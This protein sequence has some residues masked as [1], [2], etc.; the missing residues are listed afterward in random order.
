MKSLKNR[1]GTSNKRR[2]RQQGW[3]VLLY[4][5]QPPPSPC[6][7]RDLLEEEEESLLRQT[8]GHNCPCLDSPKRGGG[9][10]HLS[11][12]TG[13]KK[14]KLGRRLSSSSTTSGSGEEKGLCL[15][16]TVMVGNAVRSTRWE[17]S[18][19]RRRMDRDDA[20]W[21]TTE[22]SRATQALSSLRLVPMALLPCNSWKSLAFA[23][24][25]LNPSGLFYLNIS[26]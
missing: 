22:G 16:S 2:W 4:H 18:E 14:E 24:L 10:E 3:G 19:G 21:P 9:N 6:P 7:I 13:K 20:R 12:R 26:P 15:Q 8:C 17:T 23:F 11:A 1:R 25:H 5:R